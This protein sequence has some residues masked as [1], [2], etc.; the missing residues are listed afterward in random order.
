MNTLLLKEIIIKAYR[1]LEVV[2]KQRWVLDG[3]LQL[4]WYCGKWKVKVLNFIILMNRTECAR[5]LPV[6]LVKTVIIL[7]LLLIKLNFALAN[8][9]SAWSISTK[10]IPTFGRKKRSCCSQ[11]FRIKIVK[12]TPEGLMFCLVFPMKWVMRTSLLEQQSL[13][14]HCE[15]ILVSYWVGRN[16]AK[17]WYG[18]V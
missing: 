10:G 2:R 16:G 9:D 17:M 15:G 4:P 8:G 12:E 13:I 18:N 7:W 6:E 5:L 14:M 11:S 3:S 1:P